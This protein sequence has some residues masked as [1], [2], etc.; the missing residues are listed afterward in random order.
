M[1][2][3]EKRNGKKIITEKEGERVELKNSRGKERGAYSGILQQYQCVTVPT[4][5]KPWLACV[6]CLLSPQDCIILR[7]EGASWHTLHSDYSYETSLLLP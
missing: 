7:E 5:E 3:E 4:Q 6:F 1:G 2:V